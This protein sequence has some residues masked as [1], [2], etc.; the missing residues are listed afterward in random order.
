M[1]FEPVSTT[2][3]TGSTA[4]IEAERL[5][6]LNPL[7][8]DDFFWH[9]RW[10]IV[11]NRSDL[12]NLERWT[13][14]IWKI[15]GSPFFLTCPQCGGFSRWK[16][17]EPLTVGDPCPEHLE[18]TLKPEIVF[19]GQGIDTADAMVWQRLKGRLQRSDMIFVVGFSGSGSD[20]YLRS[21]IEE[22]P[23]AWLV[24]PGPGAWDT[25]R[26]NHVTITA[27]EFAN[28]LIEELLVE[29]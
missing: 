27:S 2:F 4:T 16:R 3:G 14:P 20:V 5:F 10:D 23:N 9:P 21:V 18:E 19:W 29:G 28:T 1:P 26:V 6:F 7:E 13:R 12:K 22:N 24:N 25:N 15:H 11:A 8:G 17:V